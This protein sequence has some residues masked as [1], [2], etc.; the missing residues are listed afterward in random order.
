MNEKTPIRFPARM[1]EV[2]CVFSSDADGRPSAFNPAPR[3]DRPNFMFPGEHIE[4][5]W[6]AYL[7]TDDAF[8]RKGSIYRLQDGTSCATPIAAAVAAGVLEF[9]WQEREYKI[10]KAKLLNHVSGMSDIIRKRMVDNYKVGD[11][12]YHY[13]KPWKFIST[14]LSKAEIPIYISDTMDNVYG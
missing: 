3:H 1:K 8:E 9:A 6:P 2:I 4:G 12:S 14:N 7:N 11:N 10:R 13:V 5:A